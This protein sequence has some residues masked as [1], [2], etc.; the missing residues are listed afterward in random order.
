MTTNPIILHIANILEQASAD[1]LRLIYMVVRAIVTPPKQA[2][3][4]STETK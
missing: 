2:E 3:A 4:N 1:Q